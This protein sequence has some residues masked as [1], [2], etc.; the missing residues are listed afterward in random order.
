[1]RI[2][3]LLSGHV[4]SYQKTLNNFEQNFINNLEE[5]GH[6]YDVFI[7]TWNN[8]GMKIAGGGESLKEIPRG[9]RRRRGNLG[10]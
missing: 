10:I 3:I 9:I 5:A 7:S 4:R 8:D 2:A 6:E 1:M